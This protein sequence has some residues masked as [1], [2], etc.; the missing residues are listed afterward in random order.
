LHT[1]LLVGASVS[2][3]GAV[4]V[5]SMRSPRPPSRPRGQSA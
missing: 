3:V 1:A 5:A 2:I 4:T